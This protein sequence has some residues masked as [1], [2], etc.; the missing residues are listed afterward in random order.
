MITLNLARI[1]AMSPLHRT[2]VS[3]VA[4]A[5]LAL[6]SGYACGDDA[7]PAGLGAA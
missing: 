7:P 2:I 6:A 4:V 1:E 3:P 5:L